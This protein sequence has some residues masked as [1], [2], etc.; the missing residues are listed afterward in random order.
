[1][2]EA[3]AARSSAHSMFITWGKMRRSIRSRRDAHE[4]RTQKKPGK[5]G[6]KCDLMRPHAIL[7]K[8]SE[9][10][11]GESNPCRRRERAVSWATRRT[12]RGDAA[13]REI[14]SFIDSG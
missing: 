8:R 2:K 11:V 3:K 9:Y 1:M 10:P 12:G 13:F 7:H 6:L 14:V 4:R 5:T